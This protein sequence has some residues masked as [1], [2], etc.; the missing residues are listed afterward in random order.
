MAPWRYLCWI[1]L[2]VM[3]LVS[4]GAAAQER[5]GFI[6]GV[7][8]DKDFGTPLAGAQVLIVETGQK[9]TTTDQG[10]FVFSQVPPGK[11]TLVFSKEGYVRQVRADAV[12]SAGQMTDLDVS[13]AGEFTDMEEFL[14]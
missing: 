13:L 4:A 3:L 8:Y 9:V 14:V 6:R 5:A 1:V 10:N 7:V 11:Y 12:V 2:G